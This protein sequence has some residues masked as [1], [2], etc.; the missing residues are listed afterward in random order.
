MFIGT[1]F[2]ARGYMYWVV[3][4]FKQQKQTGAEKG[5]DVVKLFGDLAF[6]E[7]M[8]FYLKSTWMIVQVGESD[9]FFFVG[10]FLLLGKVELVTFPIAGAMAL[11]F[12]AL[13]VVRVMAMAALD[14]DAKEEK[15]A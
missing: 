13:F 15:E 5:P 1:S 2:L 12:I 6:G 14:G 7:R 8:A 10:L 3:A 4:Y 11:W 9:V